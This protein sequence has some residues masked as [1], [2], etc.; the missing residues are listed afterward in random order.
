MLLTQVNSSTYIHTDIHVHIRTYRYTCTRTYI[1]VYMY[2][3]VHTGIHVH[4][5]TYRHTC[6]HTYIQ[7]SVF[8]LEGFGVML[9]YVLQAGYIK[10]ATPSRWRATA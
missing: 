8:S 5:R 6:T 1:Q 4:I 10:R 7:V 2:T 3:Y 9:S